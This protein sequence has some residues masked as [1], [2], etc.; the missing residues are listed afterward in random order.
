MNKARKVSNLIE[1]HGRGRKAADIEGPVVLS[2]QE[3][4]I[5]MDELVGN[6]NM[7]DLDLYGSKGIAQ[8]MVD[9][10]NKMNIKL[11]KD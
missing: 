8:D 11:M 10:L 3:A 1:T 7:S 4:F 2:D 9:T 5:V 6:I